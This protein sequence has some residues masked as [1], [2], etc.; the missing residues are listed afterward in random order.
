M[1]NRCADHDVIIPTQIAGD[2]WADGNSDEN[3]NGEGYHQ[4][5]G[6]NQYMSSMVVGCDDWAT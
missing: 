5:E 6:G 4:E 2:S 1:T 3:R